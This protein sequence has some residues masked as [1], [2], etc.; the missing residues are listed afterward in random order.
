MEKVRFT[1]GRLDKFKCPEHQKQA[2]YFDTDV[3]GLGVRVLPSGKKSFI[4][5]S[6]MHRKTIRTTIGDIRT[7]SIES[8]GIEARRLKSLC[9]QGIDPRKEKASKIEKSKLDKE[10]LQQLAITFAEAWEK[11]LSAHQTKWSAR[12]LKDHID[13]AHQGGEVRKRST[14]LTIPGPIAFLLPLRLSSINSDILEEWLKVEVDSRPTRAAL[15]FRL[16]RAFLNWCKEQNEYKDLF[17]HDAHSA[18]KVRNQVPASN[19]KD[20]CL[21]R[22]QLPYWFKEVLSCSNPVT[23]A[24]LQVLLLSGA[25]PEELTELEWPHLDF[26]WKS[27]KLSDKVNGTRVIPMTPY[28]E[29]LLIGL[30][31][32]NQWVFSSTRSESGHIEDLRTPYES[33]LGRANIPHLTFYDLRRSFGTLSE[34]VECPVGIVYQIQGHA[35]SATAEKHYRVRPLDLLRLWHIKIESWILTE[36]LIITN[37]NSVKTA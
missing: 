19:A 37:I 21:Q 20:G 32:I 6:K 14:K 27:I 28:I 15:A 13:L 9:D 3:L 11:Y 36:A 17:P 23:S 34:W 7:W 33:A 26:I 2:F 31:R 8:A 18:K 16:V 1:A 22:E 10:K 35:K 30:P 12:H 24:Y 5:E 25:R 4:F 29:K